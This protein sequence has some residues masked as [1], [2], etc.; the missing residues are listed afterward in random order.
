MNTYKNS[1]EDSELGEVAI[2]GL[3]GDGS[4]QGLK[5]SPDA[6]KT[7]PPYYVLAYIM[8]VE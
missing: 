8:R 1:T 4:T 6:V 7:L 2:K 3:T 5:S